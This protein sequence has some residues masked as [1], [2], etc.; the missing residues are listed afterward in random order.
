MS[1]K[2]MIDKANEIKEKV[3][4]KW[5]KQHKEDH[6]II[7]TKVPALPPLHN[8]VMNILQTLKLH[9]FQEKT[10]TSENTYK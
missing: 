7:C 2:E 4:S 1:E 5:Y 6:E 3:F 9:H 10:R 8:K